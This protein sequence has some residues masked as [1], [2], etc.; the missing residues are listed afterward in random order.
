MN[1]TILGTTLSGIL[2]FII[3]LI[4]TF[5]FIND[6]DKNK[7]ILAIQELKNEYVYLGKA[8]QQNYH[9]FRDTNNVIEK[10]YINPKLNVNLV[11]DE[12]ITTYKVFYDFDNSNSFYQWIYNKL[13]VQNEFSNY[14]MITFYYPSELIG[15]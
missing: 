3:P 9:Y 12:N 7:N 5:H 14:D 10:H 6:L 11:I 15:E 8:E 2:F 4:F 1:K 13:L